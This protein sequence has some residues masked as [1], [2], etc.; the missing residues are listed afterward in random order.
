M[1]N[2]KKF[3]LP[4]MIGALFNFVFLL[5]LQ[6]DAVPDSVPGF[7]FGLAAVGLILGFYQMNRDRNK[8]T[9]K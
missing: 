9:E 8:L 2:L 1:K 3:N 4:F 6:F 5:L 7:F